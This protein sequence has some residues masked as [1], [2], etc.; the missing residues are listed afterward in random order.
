LTLEN[1]V[2]VYRTPYSPGLVQALK[3]AVPSTERRWDGGRR[4]WLVAPAH[5]DALKSITQAHLGE[6]LQCQLALGHQAPALQ[7]RVLD[8][9]YVGATKDRGSDEFTAYAWSGGGWNVVLPEPVLREWFCAERRPDESPTFYATLGVK[10][11]ATEVE[12][13]S[14]YRRLALQWHPDVAK[15]SDAAEM[16]MAIKRAYD[17]LSEPM[18]R[19]RYDAGLALTE[20]T[21]AQRLEDAPFVRNMRLSGAITGYRSPLRCGLLLAEGSEVL[22]RFVVSRILSWIDISDGQGHVLVTSWPMGA[23]TYTEEWR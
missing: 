10:R 18:M 9:R 8:V 21:Q 17:V 12:V 1:G 4:A 23:D 16:F 7:T 15:E 14:A 5:L 11:G 13:K 6:T 2:L 22:G 20:R 19:A 3:S